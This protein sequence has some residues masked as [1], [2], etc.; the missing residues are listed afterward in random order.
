MSTVTVGLEG[1]PA[2]RVRYWLWQV[3]ALAL[4]SEP[5]DLGTLPYDVVVRDSTTNEVLCK[6]GPMKAWIAMQFCDD[7]VAAIEYYGVNEFVYRK[8]HGWRTEP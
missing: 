8:E 3:V 4:S 1:D 2:S 5:A 6:E 7:F